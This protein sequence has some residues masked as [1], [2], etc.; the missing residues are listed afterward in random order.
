MKLTTEN[1]FTP[2]NKYLSNSKISAFIKDKYYFKQLHIDHKIE[3]KQTPSIKLG[4][5][6]DVALTEGITPFNI[7]YQVKV[8]KKD[9]P[10]LYEYQKT[11]AE[12]L[13]FITPAE[14]DKVLAIV[15]SVA[16]QDAYKE[17][18]DYEK[19]VILQTEKKMGIWE[20]YAGVLDF[21]LIDGTTAI[22]VDLKTTQSI[23]ERKYSYS[24]EDYGYFRQMAMYSMLVYD[25]YPDVK[26]VKCRH[27]AVE[28]NDLHKVAL[29]KF[30]QL[31]IRREMA[32]IGMVMKNIAEETLFAPQNLSWEDANVLGEE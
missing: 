23:D 29:F 27:L 1:Y 28:N 7:I 22:I 30:D 9:D 10:G 25:N 18:K 31:R 14:M 21:L 32:K 2:E 8:L 17:L 5:M 11:H 13:D 4:K 26:E 20:G 16:R 3:F 24:C 6:I 12:E 15:N 19:Q